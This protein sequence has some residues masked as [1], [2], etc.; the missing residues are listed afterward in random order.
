MKIDN[1]SLPA[2]L[3]R[4]I[5]TSAICA[6]STQ[7][8]CCVGLWGAESDGYRAL[9]EGKIVPHSTLFK[10]IIKAIKE[11]KDSDKAGLND[12]NILMNTLKILTWSVAYC[13][14]GWW[15]EAQKEAALLPWAGMPY[16][17]NTSFEKGHFHSSAAG[18]G[19]F[20]SIFFNVKK[21]I[22]ALIIFLWNQGS[23]HRM[24]GRI[25]WHWDIHLVQRALWSRKVAF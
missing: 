7:P 2:G 23:H 20:K 10:D 14:Q 1:G 4:Q 6:I 12:L 16:F 11:K 3:N 5:S 18:L 21:I 15:L 9:V 25:S 8:Q 17:D 24:P 19:C 13:L 22:I